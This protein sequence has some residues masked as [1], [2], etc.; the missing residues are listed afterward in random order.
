M[1]ALVA[2]FSGC[3]RLEEDLPNPS[4]GVKTTRYMIRIPKKE[5]ISEGAQFNTSLTPTYPTTEYRA[6]FITVKLIVTSQQTPIWKQTN[7][8]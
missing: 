3:A 8:I 2:L 5:E 6:I 7:P 1:T 4:T